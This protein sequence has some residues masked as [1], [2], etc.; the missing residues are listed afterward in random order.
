MNLNLSPRRLTLRGAGEKVDLSG[1]GG[2]LKE[3]IKEG[4]GDS[5]PQ[6]ADDVNVHYTGTLEKD[7]SKFDSSLDRHS[8][9]TFKLGLGKVIKGWDIGEP[10]ALVFLARVLHA[11]NAANP[12]RG[13]RAHGKCAIVKKMQGAGAGSV[14]SGSGQSAV[15]SHGNADPTARTAGR[16]PHP[17]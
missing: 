16:L 14:G 5:M 4:E 1:D 11:S 15:R 3:I 17:A 6:K 7:G 8:P 9:F 13:S 10:A 12:A 2:V